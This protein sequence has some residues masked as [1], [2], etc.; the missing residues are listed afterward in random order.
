M[1][2][3]A[4]QQNPTLQD[5]LNGKERDEREKFPTLILVGAAARGLTV[6]NL[7]STEADTKVTKKKQP[8]KVFGI[9]SHTKKIFKKVFK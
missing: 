7:T 9:L 6:V 1:Q 4:E 2:P 3:E 8:K 5:T